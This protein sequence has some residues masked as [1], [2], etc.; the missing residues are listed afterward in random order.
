[1]HPGVRQRQNVVATRGELPVIDPADRLRIEV[2]A[3]P[4][5]R[6]WDLRVQEWW[7]D[8]WQSP[9]R[10]EWDLAD[11]HALL[12]IAYMLDEFFQAVDVKLPGDHDNANAATRVAGLKLKVDAITKLSQA[13]M[14]RSARM[15]ID[16]FS[17][18]SLQWLLVKTEQAEAETA[19]TKARTAK[20]KAET[21]SPKRRGLKALE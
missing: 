9:M 15:G 3:L 4:A 16:P 7:R 8:A 12:Q 17:R 10:L 1:M 20:T 11:T 6:L 21:P 19:A 5:E 18:R 13:I 2:P 14:N